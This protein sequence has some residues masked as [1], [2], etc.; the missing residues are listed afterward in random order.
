MIYF[1]CSMNLKF[2]RQFLRILWCTSFR[3]LGQILITREYDWK[4]K[5]VIVCKEEWP[6]KAWSTW[7]VLNFT[8]L[9]T[10]VNREKVFLC[11]LSVLAD[12]CP[13]EAW[14]W[15]KTRRL[16]Q[17][18]P[19]QKKLSRVLQCFVAQVTNKLFWFLFWMLKWHFQQ[20]FSSIMV[21]SLTGG[22]N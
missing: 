1:F 2:C 5:T 4:H 17:N 16:S 22:V 21:V 18:S 12:T 8:E 11:P 6:W 3:M 14:P 15:R 7:H 20:Y 9:Y 19:S 13:W 10:Y